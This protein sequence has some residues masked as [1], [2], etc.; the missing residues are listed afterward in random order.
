MTE[1]VS[2][3]Q[4]HSYARAHMNTHTHTH[5]L[6]EYLD[7]SFFF[8]FFFF[9]FLVIPHSM[10]NL[11]ALTRN[12]TY[13]PTHWKCRVLTIG[14]LG[15]PWTCNT[16][17]GLKCCPR[18]LFSASLDM[19]SSHK[20]STKKLTSIRK[21][22]LGIVLVGSI[23]FFWIVNTHYFLWSLLHSSSWLELSLDLR[24]KAKEKMRETPFIGL[25]RRSSENIH[26]YKTDGLIW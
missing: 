2:P 24:R 4:A 8:F 3:G 19:H 12:G 21:W 13:A 22:K 10:W 14:P 6:S 17:C 7:M 18:G 23:L 5:T 26:K 11:I 25:C 1:E 16:E 9:N 15:S 20:S